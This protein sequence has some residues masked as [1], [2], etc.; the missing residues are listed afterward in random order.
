MLKFHHLQRENHLNP[1]LKLKKGRGLM[2]DKTYENIEEIFAENTS[3]SKQELAQQ[4][5]ELLKEIKNK[6]LTFCFPKKHPPLKLKDNTDYLQILVEFAKDPQ[7]DKSFFISEEQQK[8]LDNCQ[9]AKNT[10]KNLMWLRFL[11]TLKKTPSNCIDDYELLFCLL[12]FVVP[13]RYAHRIAKCLLDEYET[14]ENVLTAPAGE[15]H[16]LLF[17]NKSKDVIMLLEI[18]YAILRKCAWEFDL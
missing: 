14:L 6:P 4:Q 9:S 8:F 11:E 2:V 1:L 17:F 18:L 12:T 10:I 15:L 7:T 3:P 16:D 13:M 5:E